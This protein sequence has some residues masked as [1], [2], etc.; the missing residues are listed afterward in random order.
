MTDQQ[1][2]E[3]S[4][5]GVRFCSSCQSSQH[6]AGGV[7]VVINKGKNRRWRCVTC[8]SACRSGYANKKSEPRRLNDDKQEGE[9][10]YNSRKVK[11]LEKSLKRKPTW[12]EILGEIDKYGV[13][14]RG[15]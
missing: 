12:Q 4:P 1:P 11:A 15:V 8:Q 7:W 6:S 9:L 14:K 2:A 13:K 10:S 5:N 3:V